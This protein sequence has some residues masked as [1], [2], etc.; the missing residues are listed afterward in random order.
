MLE[1]LNVK[2][3]IVGHSERREIFNESN[4]Q[5]NSKIKAIFKHSMTPILCVG[6][7]IEEREEGQAEIK[8]R[9][10]LEEGLNGIGRERIGGMVIAYEPIWAIGT[11][12]TAT[13]EDAQSMC[14]YVRECVTSIAGKSAS[15][16]VRIQYGGSV[17]PINAAEL[18]SQKDIDGAL[19]GGA[20]LEA[21]TFAR[22]IQYRLH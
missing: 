2:L 16:T 5:V 7:T 12:V 1:K 22:I 4:E 15:E 14:A 13:P 9:A 10:Q 19:V 21:D 3:V 11:G 6:E 17:K 8:V 20:A 18:M